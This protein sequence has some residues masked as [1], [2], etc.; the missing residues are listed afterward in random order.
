MHLTDFCDGLLT[1]YLRNFDLIDKQIR[2]PRVDFCLLDHSLVSFQMTAVHLTHICSA[3][4]LLPKWGESFGVIFQQQSQLRIVSRV[5]ETI[6]V[7]F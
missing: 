2:I 1:S 5:Y 6:P 4:S 3:E 7:R